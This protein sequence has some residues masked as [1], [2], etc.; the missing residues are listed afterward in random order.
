M[1]MWKKGEK[2]DCLYYDLTFIG[3]MPLWQHTSPQ[4]LGEV[5]MLFILLRSF[6]WCIFTSV[7][8]GIQLLPQLNSLRHCGTGGLEYVFKRF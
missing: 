4:F 8:F 1:T 7:A 6:Y 3:C 2:K 5:S